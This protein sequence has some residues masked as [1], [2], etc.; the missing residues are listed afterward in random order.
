MVDIGVDS[1]AGF[2]LDEGETNRFQKKR[3]VDKYW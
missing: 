2:I 1:N 3:S